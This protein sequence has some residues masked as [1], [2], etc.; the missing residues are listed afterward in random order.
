MSRIN[1]IIARC[2]FVLCVWGCFTVAPEELMVA[3][4]TNF[5]T[6]AE[7]L[8]KQ[9]EE[10]SDLKI[11]LVAGSS[12]QLFAQAKNG[13]PYDVFFSADQEKIEAIVEESLGIDDSRITYARGRLC[14]MV[15][16]KKDYKQNAGELFANLEFTRIVLANPKLA[17]YGAAAEEVFDALEIDMKKE[18]KKVILADNVGKA[19]AIVNTGNADV[20]M[21]ALSSVLDDEL[22]D[23]YFYVLPAK[24][25]SPLRQDAIILSRTKNEASA[26]EFIDFVQSDD[27]KAIIRNNGYELD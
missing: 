10:E 27:A 17:P 22:S 1:Q 4:A 19:Y 21:V 24:H 14:F 12:G 2:C 25:Y 26:R 20:G 15:N 8:I 23:E 9:F 18:K 7:E 3:V 13:A 5:L 6:T 16:P 11:T